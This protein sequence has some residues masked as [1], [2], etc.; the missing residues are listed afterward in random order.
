MMNDLS[1]QPD[2]SDQLKKSVVSWKHLVFGRNL[3]RTLYRALLIAVV[4]FIVFHYI[5]L[6]VRV[7]GISM[8]PTYRDGR[9]NL[10][11]RLAYIRHPPRRAD[12]VA[13]RAS[14]FHL[15]YLKRVIALPNETFAI[16]NGVVLINDRPLPEP[17]LIRPYPWNL[18]PRKLGS[19]EYYLIG[20]N[21]RMPQEYHSFGTAQ[22]DHIVG[23]VLW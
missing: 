19:D 6:P 10:V 13:I 3:E 4:C 2:S 9:I 7:S 23:K 1:D 18:P 5:L 14:G 11:N 8:E 17:Y 22:A 15:M 16:T 20:D 21:R 12:V